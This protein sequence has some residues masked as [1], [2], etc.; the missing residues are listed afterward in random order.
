MKKISGISMQTEGTS[1]NYVTLTIREEDTGTEKKTTLPATYEPGVVS[2]K[3]WEQDG[4][5]DFVLDKQMILRPVRVAVNTSH[6]GLMLNMPKIMSLAD[7]GCQ[8]DI[9]T[10][11]KAICVDMQAREYPIL[12]AAVI[13]LNNYH[14][15]KSDVCKKCSYKRY[16][17]FYKD[18]N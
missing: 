8:E 11:A 15:E 14:P 3:D 7:S 9:Y 2:G 16:C 10:L 4:L 6:L 5:L 13:D 1:L 12:Q 17:L 18:N